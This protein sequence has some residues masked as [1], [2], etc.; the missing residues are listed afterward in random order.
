[1]RLLVRSSVQTYSPRITA[2]LWNRGGVNT[3][4]KN[5]KVF[6]DNILTP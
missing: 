6:I 2:A 1:M 5:D 3:P 4:F